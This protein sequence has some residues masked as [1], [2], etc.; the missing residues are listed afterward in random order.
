MEL[1]EQRHP[2]QNVHQWERLASIVAGGSLALYGVRQGL[3]HQSI[4]ASTGLTLAGAALIKRGVTGYC[5]LY[6][7]LGVTTA[8][9]HP[10]ASA[11]V[12]YQQGV[13]VDRS[14]TINAGR[15]QVYDFWRKLENLPR[16]MRHVHCVK[17][18]DEKHSH[19]IVDAPA[20]QKVEWDA[21]II[22]EVPNELLA[23]RSLPGA[24]IPNAGSVR[25]EHATAGRGTKVTVSLQYEPIAGQLGV[26]VAKLFGKDPEA[27]VD[28][29]LHRLK[30]IIEAGEVPTSKGQPTG[31]SDAKAEQV[32]QK[33]KKQDE[34]HDASE[35]SFPASDPP[36]HSHVNGV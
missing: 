3:R 24:S 10:G 11:S 19:W 18:T 36:S 31:R 21:E 12:G 8:E 29:E 5:D 2:L 35:A 26:M 15:S 16:F 28:S 1:V 22:N 14:I 27:E 23:W 9:E 4:A 6:R 34:V 17:E 32:H 20:G 30:S 7:A 25:F 13:R 33:A